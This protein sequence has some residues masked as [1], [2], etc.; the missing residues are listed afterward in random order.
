MLTRL[1]KL[2]TEKAS[3][4][5]QA[6]LERAAGDGPLVRA[7]ED[8]FTTHGLALPLPREEH[9]AAARRQRRIEAVPEPLRPAA[10]E[11]AEHLLAAR[12]RARKVGTRPRA[13]ATL[14]ARLN[15]VRDLAVY[16]VTERGKTDWAT[17]EIGDIEAFLHG[18]S[19][20]RRASHLAGLRQFFRFAHQR[21]LVLT[22]PTRGMSAPQPTGFRGPT[23]TMQR[24]RDLF[25][26]W[27]TQPG[28][29]PHEAFV[30]LLA[31]LH[32]ATTSELQQLTDEAIHPGEHSI[33]LGKRPQVTPLDPWTWT[34]LQNCLS[35]RQALASTNPHLLVTTQTKATR[36]P[37]SDGYI[38][39]TLDPVGIQPR[40]LRSSRLVELV[41]SV[42]A[43]LV[44]TAYG[45]T[46]DAVIAYLADHVDATRLANP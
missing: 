23:L 34:A 12:Q 15:A 17:V 37:A 26:R 42:D 10:A 44:A 39:H 6:L 27:T 19:S 30:G 31:L 38:K 7:L 35:H 4:H 8:F 25:Q 24:Q 43:T 29:H 2:L 14:D 45:M 9:Q 41:T 40:I 28:I 36:A 13:L 5:P 33:T 3:T 16:L 18:A 46:N 32:G 20:S 11:F 21:R 22:D 1:G